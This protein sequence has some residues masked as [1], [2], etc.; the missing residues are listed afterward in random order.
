MAIQGEKDL[1]K[2]LARVISVSRRFSEYL[3]LPD[4]VSKSINF[5]DHA[6]LSLASTEEQRVWRTIRARDGF[7]IDFLTKIMVDLV[8]S[9][10]KLTVI[11]N[12]MRASVGLEVLDFQREAIQE[13]IKR[14]KE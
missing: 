12:Q 10:M 5:A 6:L 8:L 7:G 11:I 2:A 9:V 3:T 1:L 14:R 13:D 4:Q